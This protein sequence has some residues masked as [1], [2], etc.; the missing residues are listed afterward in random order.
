M[1]SI[2]VTHYCKTMGMTMTG[3]PMTIT[4]TVNAPADYTE[5]TTVG[6]CRPADR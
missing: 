4:S 5:G 1:L 3:I 2:A 6:D